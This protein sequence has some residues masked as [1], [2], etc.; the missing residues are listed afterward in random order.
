MKS[1]ADLVP[2][3]PGMSLE[4]SSLHRR[5]EAFKGPGKV[6]TYKNSK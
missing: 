3:S 5:K 4:M 1:A 6:I 2:W